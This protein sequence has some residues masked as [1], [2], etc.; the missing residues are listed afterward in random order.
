MAV[1]FLVE[2]VLPRQPPDAATVHTDRAPLGLTCDDFCS[3]HSSSL[4]ALL[5]PLA[6][7]F[8]WGFGLGFFLIST[9]FCFRS[10]HFFPHCP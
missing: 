8:H 7:W 1:A 4:L 5:E 10:L 3:L 9:I 2:Q 6:M